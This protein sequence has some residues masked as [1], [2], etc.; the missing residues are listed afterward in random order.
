[1][2]PLFR[3]DRRTVLRHGAASLAA[4]SILLPA[5]A[6]TAREGRED[7]VR[8][9]LIG[10]GGRGTGAANQALRTDGPVRLVAMADVFSDRLESSLHNL[11]GQEALEG[12]IDVPAER[13]FSGFDAFEKAIACDVDLVILATPP[14][15]RP[16]H[17]AA[18]VAAGKHVFMEKPVAVDGA[19]VRTV[20]DAGHEAS[21]KGLK[22]V[23]GLQ[24]HYQGGYLA[25]L[26]K[27]RAG[28]IGKI[29]AAR[30]YWNMGFLW[31]RKREAG[32]SDMEWQLRN[33][34]YF[35]WASG[36]HIVEQ[37][38][39]NLDVVNWFVGDFPVRCHGMGGRE[40]RTDPVNGHIFDHHA[41]HYEYADGTFLASQCRQIA[42]CRNE[43]SEHLIGT[44]GRLMM[45]TGKWVIERYDGETWRYSKRNDNPYQIEHD[46]LMAAI[47][48]DQPHNDA[49]YGARSTLTAI[50]G[51]IATYS[52]KEVLAEQVLADPAHLGPDH[53][54]MGPLPLPPVAV[55][56][57]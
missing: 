10:C 55:P 43:V 24:R 32:W 31:S 42:G 40:V 21:Q 48:T 45:D 57:S 19:G 14:H 30:A 37:H 18:A 52:G 54:A 3:P 44:E 7:E 16:A 1:M 56:G 28:M 9:A 41:V 13:R 50:M 39:H 4:G 33:W 23:V 26:E 34:L 47:R 2:P 22:V 38:V 15:F 12:K 8:I 5:A 29:V 6:Q 49:E 11:K 25:A 36:D 46:R 17:F 53:Y 35:A 27:V 20:L 51:R